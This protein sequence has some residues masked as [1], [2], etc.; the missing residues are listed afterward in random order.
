M[1][2]RR[3]LHGCAMLLAAGFMLGCETAVEP[4]IGEERPFTIWGL[5]NSGAD[6]QK[7]RVFS[8]ADSPGVDR[9]E[10]IDATVSSMDLTTGERREWSHRAVT[11][12]DGDVG[13]VFW[14]PFRAQNGHRYRLDVTRSDGAAST[15][16]VTV[17]SGVEVTLDENS[18]S[19]KF[20][21]Y[22]RGDAPNLIDVEMRYEATNVPPVN[23]WPTD[24]RVHPPV[25]L[26]VDVSYQNTGQ[27]IEDGWRFD[28]DMQ[29]DF[30][31]VRDV[32]RK[33]C[34]ITA[35]APDIALSGVEFHFI[36]ADSAWSPP[37]GTFDPDVLVEPGVFSNVE[38]GYGFFGAGEVVAVRWT[39]PALLRKHVGYRDTRPCVD[40]PSPI[41][42][43]MEPPVPCMDDE[44]E[45]FWE[46]Y[47]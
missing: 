30:E 1:L 3:L 26:P 46:I 39:P 37:D 10:G 36:A 6:T 19:A 44:T 32:Y 34:L 38:N 20:P 13:H 41:Q 42:A 29:E 7:V 43:C 11:Y 9:S 12:E 33:N 45:G 21:V 17:P 14:A 16:T 28:I 27:R 23:V 24:R 22:I 4:H 2:Y 40:D 18:T 47:F 31:V 15:A 8:I 25:F 5:M 35:G